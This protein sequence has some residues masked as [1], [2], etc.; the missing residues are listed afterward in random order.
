MIIRVELVKRDIESFKDKVEK[1]VYADKRLKKAIGGNIEVLVT[2]IGVSNYGARV[3]V[4]VP[5]EEEAY[6]TEK[7][8]GIV[9][10]V[11]EG[12]QS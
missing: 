8:S 2:D 6:T 3:R 10:F 12:F 4:T 1:R 11:S 7:L 9:L 5:V